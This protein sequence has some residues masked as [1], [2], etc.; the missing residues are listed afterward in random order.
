MRILTVITGMALMLT[1]IWCFAER[2]AV[3]SN[4]AFILGCAMVFAG[5]LSILIYFFAPGKQTGFGWFLAEG[6]ITLILGGVVLSN[7]LA[8]DSM[9]P[10]FFGMWVLFCGVMR[11]VASLHLIMVKNNSWI[12]NLALGLISMV[13]GG[14]AFFNQI[15]A[16]ITVIILTGVYFLIQG[17]NV[18]VYGV[19]IPGK[20]R[21]K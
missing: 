4:I 8:T 16:G 18:L 20:K 9:V 14:Y 1:G 15:A 3:F 17:V 13:A 19:F 5:V 10:F 12:V 11:A 7:Q 2:G 21:L 6:I